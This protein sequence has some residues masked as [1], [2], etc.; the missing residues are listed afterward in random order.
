LDIRTVAAHPILVFGTAGGMVLLKLLVIAP[1]MRGFSLS[2]ATGLRAGAAEP[3]A[4]R[5]GSP[6]QL[7][8]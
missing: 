1:L 8:P 2:W 7:R 4:R 5:V 3:T 6:A